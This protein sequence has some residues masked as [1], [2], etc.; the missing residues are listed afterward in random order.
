MHRHFASSAFYKL[1][2]AAIV[3][4]AA[5]IL[6]HRVSAQQIVRVTDSAGLQAAIRSVTDGGVIELAAGTYAAPTGGFTI[7]DVATTRSFTIKSAAGTSP[8]LSGGGSR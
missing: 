4:A 3:L 8:I 7:S 6:P 1:V 2:V 5:A